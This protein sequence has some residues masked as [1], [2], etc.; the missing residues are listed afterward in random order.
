MELV[1]P[2]EKALEVLA[3]LSVAGAVDGA[4]DANGFPA[5][6]DDATAGGITG[7]A[8]AAGVEKLKRL[9]FGGATLKMGRIRQA[10]AYS[11]ITY[12]FG[13]AGA[14][15]AGGALGLSAGA[16]KKLCNPDQQLSHHFVTRTYRRTSRTR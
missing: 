2:K 12:P 6:N 15:S 13:S 10:R 9:V 11:E 16:E 1:L 5:G 14:A 7:A 4:T 3:G 8:V